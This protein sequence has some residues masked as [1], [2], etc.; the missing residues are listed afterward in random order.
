M[1]PFR[2]L[3]DIGDVRGKRALVRVDLNVPMKNG[4]ATDRTRI[5]RVAPTI[6]ELSDK[7]AKVVLLAHFERPKGKLLLERSSPD[8]FCRRIRL[9]GPMIESIGR[10]EVTSTTVHRASSGMCRL[11]QAKS[12]V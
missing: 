2:T 1:K 5:V 6:R 12:R 10:P 11:S 4:R 8:S 3:D 7:G 9:L